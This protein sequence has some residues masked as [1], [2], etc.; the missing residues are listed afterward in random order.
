MCRGEGV[1]VG[2]MIVCRGG[3]V[4]ERGQG[5]SMY[6]GTARGAWGTA[7][8]REG[9]GVQH[10]EE[11]SRGLGVQ[12]VEEK[13]RGAWG[14][15][16]GGEGAEVQP[17]EENS[18][19]GKGTACEGEQQ[20]G[21]GVQFVVVMWVVCFPP[22]SIT[23]LHETQIFSASNLYQHFKNTFFISECMLYISV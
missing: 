21:V 20:G 17:V 7:C 12:H 1:R 16:C 2:Y 4:G 18:R 19:G 6:K 22:R 8:G 13:S 9:A 23:G 11:N 5:Y 14:T 3:Y 10:V 15:A